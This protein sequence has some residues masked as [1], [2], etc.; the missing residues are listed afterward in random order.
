MTFRSS[1]SQNTNY[2]ITLETMLKKACTIWLCQMNCY[3]FVCIHNIHSHTHTQTNADKKHEVFV[4]QQITF[5]YHQAMIC[6]A[7]SLT[8]LQ[9]INFPL[10]IALIFLPFLYSVHTF[11]KSNARITLCNEWQTLCEFQLRKMVDRI[12]YLSHSTSWLGLNALHIFNT[13][14]FQ[15]WH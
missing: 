6:I 1:A 15:K 5:R 3:Y 12:F 13:Y 2:K 11:S 8:T 10:H 7:T 9:I 14:W 4:F